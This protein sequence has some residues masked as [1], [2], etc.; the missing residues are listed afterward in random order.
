MWFAHVPGTIFVNIHPH[1][2]FYTDI[3]F[4]VP[5][6]PA[7]SHQ[8]YSSSYA[9]RSSKFLSTNE[10]ETKEKKWLINENRAKQSALTS[11][12]LKLT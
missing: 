11:I 2:I 5:Y 1:N 4:R 3:A 9:I 10:K 12:A 8:E 7:A 6:A